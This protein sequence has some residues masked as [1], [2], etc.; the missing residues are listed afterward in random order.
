MTRITDRNLFR[1][2]A[3]WYALDTGAPISQHD[4]EEAARFFDFYDIPVDSL[5]VWQN[6]PDGSWR[7]DDAMAETIKELASATAAGVVTSAITAP[8]G[9]PITATIIAATGIGPFAMLIGIGAMLAASVRG[10]FETNKRIA[11]NAG[12]GGFPIASRVV[13]NF[14]P[15]MTERWRGWA[16]NCV[17]VFA[18]SRRWTPD[19][20]GPEAER[21]GPQYWQKYQR[22]FPNM[23]TD[24]KKKLSR[25]EQVRRRR[26]QRRVANG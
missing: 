24:G 10:A 13:F 15:R 17:S 19:G 1:L 4:A 20:I 16:E 26:T 11:G 22:W 3:G 21:Y 9:V 14:G 12:A 23:K 5:Q 6:Y 25:R 7:R 18:A 8:V 2:P